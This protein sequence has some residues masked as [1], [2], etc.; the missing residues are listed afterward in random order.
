VRGSVLDR[1]QIA[2]K[3]DK[4]DKFGGEILKGFWV[5]REQGDSTGRHSVALVP[6]V[7]APQSEMAPSSGAYAH[8]N[9][10]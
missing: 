2:D 6:S 10:A 4:I 8:V 7:N 5:L 1:P 9:S 3:I